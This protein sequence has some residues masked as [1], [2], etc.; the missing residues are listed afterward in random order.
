MK[1]ANRPDSQEG[2][3]L[4]RLGF[5]ALGLLLVLPFLLIVYLFHEDLDAWRIFTLTFLFLAACLG[6]YLLWRVLRGVSHILSGLQKISRGEANA[7]DVNDESSQLREMA[8]IINALNKL[9]EEFR[10]NASQLERFIQQFATLAEMTEITANVPD[11]H[12]LFQLVLKKA[13]TATHARVGSVALMREEGDGLELVAWEGWTPAN[14]GPIS[15]DAYLGRSVFETGSPLLVEDIEKSPLTLRPNNKDTYATHSFL[16]MPLKTKNATIGAVSLADKATGEAFHVHDQQFLAVLLAQMGYAVE[17][18]R[19]LRQA[20][21]AANDLKRTVEVQ[22]LE[23]EEARLKMLQT[24]KLSALGQLAG[25]VAHDFNNLLQAILGY[26]SLA[27]KHLRSD[28]ARTLELEQIRKA[29]ERAAALTRQLLAFGRRQAIKPQTLDLNHV[30]NDVMVM[31]RRLIGEDIRLDIVGASKELVHVDPQQIEQ[32]L[33][34]LCV[35][36]RDAMPDG[37]AIR[38]ETSDVELSEILCARNPWAEPGRYVLLT[39]SDNGCG[40]DRT[41]QSRLFEPFFTTKEVGKGTGLG[42][43]TV[44]GILRQHKGVINVASEVGKGT[45][46][47]VY[48]P[49]GG[50]SAAAEAAPKVEDVSCGGNETILLA[51]DDELVRSLN[52]RVLEDAGYRVLAACDGEEAIRLFEQHAD[53]IALAIL[54]AVMPKY[55]GLEIQKRIRALRPNTLLLFC[56]GYNTSALW[57]GLQESGDYQILNKPFAPEEFLAKVRETLDAKPRR[58]QSALVE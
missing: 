55:S 24:E 26:T 13:L 52:T 19:L 30:V 8:F 11:I 5:Q 39:V 1:K 20:R 38:I 54:D 51:E 31:V 58:P 21:Y 10:E 7:L 37:G 15:M 33:I 50:A 9:T 49:A 4:F 12:E 32:V 45:T 25:G 48:L 28:P 23:L 42:L 27:M 29:A 6:F 41:V 18:S 46:F 2:M 22:G 36:A 53:G 16:I 47:S 35:N 44:Y 3:G 43:S 34:N 57:D 17:N 56:S 14:P 40:M